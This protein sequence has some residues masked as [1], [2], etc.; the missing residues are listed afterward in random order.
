MDR[1]RIAELLVDADW[2]RAHHGDAGM[3][4]P[5]LH[6]AE[7]GMDQGLDPNPMFDTAWYR[8]THGAAMAPGVSPCEDFCRNAITALRDPGPLF[9]TAWYCQSYPDIPAAGINPLHHYLSFGRAERRD[10]SPHF[11]N[12]WYFYAYPFA[13]SPGMDAPTHFMNHGAALGLSPSPF[14]DL[15]WY[16]AQYPEV[17]RSGMNPLLHYL[18][19][20]EAKG[21]WPAPGFDPARYA[22]RHRKALPDARGALRHFAAQHPRRRE[23]YL[24][25]K[26]PPS[27]YIRAAVAAEARAMIALAGGIEADLADLPAALEQLPVVSLALGTAELAWRRLYLSLDTVPRRILLA[28]RLDDLP[29]LADLPDDPA[30]LVLETD[31]DEVS[32]GRHLPRRVVARSLSAISPGL[33]EPGRARVVTA[34]LNAFRPAAI[35]AWGS[36][37]GG[38][39]IARHGASL[40]VDAKLFIAWTDAPLRDAADLMRRHFRRSLP[41]VALSYA[42]DLA[43]LHALADDFGL[44]EGARGH[45]RP[46][47]AWRAAEGFLGPE[48]HAP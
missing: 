26:D 3:G 27:R 44:P 5:V 36:H 32:V 1:L 12:G 45:F 18:L 11:Q 31:G 17:A 23:A 20:G 39:A 37:A 22:A 42:A 14:F 8:A 34:L 10:P 15:A 46:L 35:M 41:H 33:D 28:G 21:F 7:Q 9:D 2:Y 13:D 43:A 30:L 19:E 48:G 40:Q 24:Q 29:E 6:F 47:G 16:R 38:E 25:A 4:D